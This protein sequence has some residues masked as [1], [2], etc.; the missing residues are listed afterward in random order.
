MP[1]SGVPALEG[2]LLR[3]GGAYV[4]RGACY[5]VPG[6]D[7][8]PGRLLMRVVRILLECIL[9]WQGFLPKKTHEN[10]INW[11][12]TGGGVSLTSH[13]EPPMNVNDF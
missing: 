10:E 9:V 13:L 2:C 5:G 6:G 7:P 1:T 11:T 4:W 3:R 12:G 8:P